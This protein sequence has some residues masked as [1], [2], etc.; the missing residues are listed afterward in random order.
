[1]PHSRPKRPETG[2]W[3]HAVPGDRQARDA[4]N[5]QGSG[6]FGRL[7]S[8]P[9]ALPYKQEVTGSIPVP[10]IYEIPA[11]AGFSFSSRRGSEAWAAQWAAFATAEDEPP[12]LVVEERDL[13]RRSRARG[14]KSMAL[15][16]RRRR[17]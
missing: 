3:S 10:P 1:V 16:T 5:H 17:A 6:D 9:L 12:V 15:P 8:K 2:P 13:S 4:S 14:S 7:G 11:S